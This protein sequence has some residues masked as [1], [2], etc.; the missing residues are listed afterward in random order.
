MSYSVVFVEDE[1][2][3][4]EEIASSIRWDLLGL[5]LVGTASDGLVER[6]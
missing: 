6:T 4:R 5:E 2:I 3:V 1:Q